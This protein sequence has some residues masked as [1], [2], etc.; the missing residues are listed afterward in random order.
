[1]KKI[2]TSI[3]LCLLCVAG[4]S[5]STPIRGT[6]VASVDRMYEFVKATNSS[7]DRE[8]AEKFYSVSQIY[9]IRGDIALCQSIIE[10]GW[11]KYTGGTAVT[12]DDHNY[13]GL[14]VTTLGQKGCQFDTVEEGVTA[15]MQHLYAYACNLALP[16]GETL[17]DPRFKYVTRGSAP[18]WEDLGGVWAT[19][20]NY[21]TKILAMYEDMMAFSMPE[22]SLTASTLSVNLSGTK[23]GTAPSKTVTITGANLTS[24][25]AYNSSSSAFKVSVSNWNDYTGGTMTITLDTTKDAGSYDGYIAVQSGSDSST[26]IEINCT[27][28]IKEAGTTTTPSLSFTEG[29]NYGG[30]AGVASAWDATKIRNFDYAD[31][32]LYCVY[33]NSSIKVIDARTG[34]YIKDLDVSSSIVSGGACTLCDVK[35][36]DGY[37]IACNLVSASG[38]IRVY[39][40]A[41]DDAAPVLLHSAAV[42]A[43]TGDCLGVY[44]SVSGTLRL[45]FGSTDGVITEYTRTSGT[46]SSKTIS[47][48]ITTGTAT[49]VIPVSGGYLIDGR[50]IL[51]TMVNTSGT[52]QYAL[53]NESVADGNGFS[54]FTYDGKTYMMVSTYLNKTSTLTEGAMHLFDVTSGWGS[55]TAVDY[56]PSAGL[57]TT[58]NT[59]LATSVATNAGDDYAEAWV[60]VLGQGMAYYKSGNVPSSGSTPVVTPTL[61]VS[62]TALSFDATVG[63]PVSKTLT[64]TGTSLTSNISLALSGTDAGKFSLSSSSL[65]SSGSVTVTYN[66]SAAGSHSATLTISSTGATSLT[67][68]LTGTASDAT[69]EVP[70]GVK[71]TQD[72]AVTSGLPTSTDARW[73]AG[74]N[75]KMYTQDKTNAKVICWNGTS[76]TEIATGTAGW[77]LT[78]DEA[79]NLILQNALWSTGSVTFMILP[80]GKTSSSDL[81]TLTV[82]PPSGCAAGA[83]HTI[84]RA[85]GNVMSATGGAFYTLAQNQTQISKIYVANGAQVASKCAAIGLGVS[86]VTPGT[87]SVVQ[88]TNNDLTATDN[89]VWMSRSVKNQ[90]MKL[91][92]NAYTEYAFNNDGETANTTAGGDIITLSDITYTIE[93]SGENYSDGFV[94]V[95]RSNDKVVYTR[96]GTGVSDVSQS[97]VAFE[98]VNET[99]ANVYHYT[100]G[101]IA[102][103][104]TMTLE[105]AS[106][107]ENV[108]CETV[109][110]ISVSGNTLNVNGVEAETVEVYS[111]AGVPECKADRTNSIDVAGLNGF[112]V[113]VV[114][115]VD[116]KILTRKIAI[117]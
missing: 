14:G 81:V 57:G 97:Y 77:C 74:Y 54:T 42:T 23:G 55:A 56:Y 47:T 66:P 116:G 92:G 6:I 112:Y 109:V 45:T 31:G 43:R 62:A 89:V 30:I 68:S 64:V 86:D 9:G 37:I 25:I 53:A 44:G 117:R 84:G 16:S 4:A 5:A 111:I 50:S 106:G 36:L 26:R 63:T 80:A 35:C 48:G 39:S 20:T 60:S 101:I 95:D 103:K 113:V 83:M 107:V 3:A 15:Q 1:M 93:P 2:I 8:I 72:W 46:W 96:E 51:P 110:S 29:W 98:K 11:F 12:A 59:N 115:G 73:A 61:G 105:Q 104:Y 13:C 102:A 75:G 88:P 108:A 82:T 85:I 71:L 78:A 87:Q 94:I 40:W 90:L 69:V 7:F 24:A 49:R 19:A 76:T 52:K 34:E 33:D 67:V 100:P 41:G 99:T 91:D 32:K 70:G 22:A 28:T 79:G 17:I 10:T 38:E 114:K 27:G 58:R 65:A 21:G 18:N